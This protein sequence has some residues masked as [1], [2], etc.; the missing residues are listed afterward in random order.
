[1]SCKLCDA[2]PTSHSFKFKGSF[3]SINYYYTCPAEATN[4]DEQ[5]IVTHFDLLLSKNN[6]KKWA[7]IFDCKGFSS[8]QLL[9]FNTG[10]ALIKLITSKYSDTLERI[11]IINKNVYLNAL[12]NLLSPFFNEKIKSLITNL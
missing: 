3:N 1:M 6:N 5:A 4:Y 9:E 10:I 8:R 11:I 2:D 12:L 7:F